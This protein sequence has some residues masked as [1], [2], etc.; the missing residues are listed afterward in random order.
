VN[1]IALGGRPNDTALSRP[2]VDDMFAE[3]I[4]HATVGVAIADPAG[5]F[6][7]VNPAYCAIVGR[8]EA[9][10]LDTDFLS[11]THADDL[12]E[13]LALQQQ[14]LAGA[15]THYDLEKRYLKGNGDVAWVLKRVSLRRDAAGQ[16]AY[17]VALCQ[18][19]TERKRAEAERDALLIAERSVRAEAEA[20]RETYRLLADLVPG[21]VWTATAGG[22]VDYANQ[23]W[24]HYTGVTF[25]ETRGRKWILCLHPDDV[26][27]VSQIW[28]DAQITGE[29]VEVE[30]RLRRHDG[31]YRWFLA[32]G[33]AVPDPQGGIAKWFGLLT[34]ID[35]QK[36]AAQAL[37][38]A[39]R[40]AENANR[41]KSEFLSR[42]SHELRTPLNAILGFAQLLEMAG[43]S[44][45]QQ[46]HIEQILK[47]GRHLL[48]LINE[49]L[50]L[51][52]IEAGT[53]PLSLTPLCVPSLFAQVLDLM[54]PLA[55]SR[56]IALAAP[57]VPKVHVLGD[58]KRLVQVLL[59]LIGNAIKYNRECG[60]VTL[61]LEERPE[62]RIRLL[63]CD[64]GP[65]LTAAQQERVFNPFER[66]G[67]EATEI[68]GT[69]LGL[70]VS[71]RLTEAMGG[72]LGIM[73]TGPE[74]STFFVELPKTQVRKKPTT[75]IITPVTA[76][77]VATRERRVL[78]IEDNA[79]NRTLIQRVLALR[80]GFRLET[81]THGREGLE[82]ARRHPPDLIL[83][84]MQLPDM[85]GADVLRE[86]RA[87]PELQ[88]IP[89]LILSADVTSPRA[90]RLLAA[91]ASDYLT[92]P[93]DV[94]RFLEAVDR[95][96]LE[97]DRP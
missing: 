72:T 9:D 31:V 91:G 45:Q 6:L 57:P 84:D 30:Y 10:L 75:G 21:V 5:R 23:F 35:D 96:L 17:C 61:T 90:D 18:D 74:G 87:E 55:E 28:S 92:K 41:A 68:E 58:E 43:A 22:D 59:N 2:A 48:G 81:A 82:W 50:D 80:P 78:Y 93:I 95:L 27:R 3:A 33:K 7:Y 97:G 60:E 53:M 67:A 34:D 85:T 49:V 19:I 42:M 77:S 54:R 71:K 20:A 46:L 51:A 26:A 36:Q 89:V 66:L 56:G 69:G 73:T 52:R 14:M 44:E 37:Q 40:A 63:V 79:A 13:D 1:P 8:T 24:F 29:F 65:G 32:R 12:V 88:P 70:S 39:K 15:F 94:A 86:L 47:G 64:T 4:A 25:E 83:L 76:R 38:E 11:L 62:A 16:P